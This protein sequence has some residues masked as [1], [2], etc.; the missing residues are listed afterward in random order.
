MVT[1]QH[2]LMMWIV[3]TDSYIHILPLQYFQ[4]SAMFLPPCGLL[5]NHPVLVS[6]NHILS[7][8]PYSTIQSSSKPW[9]YK[10]KFFETT[11]F[12]ERMKQCFILIFKCLQHKKHYNIFFP[13]LLNMYLV[14]YVLKHFPLVKISPSIKNIFYLRY[15]NS[16]RKFFPYWRH[17]PPLKMFPQRRKFSPTV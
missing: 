9:S 12:K 2:F 15:I 4:C 1:S 17:F 10:T 16:Q 5:S 11:V 6:C 14:R 7:S 3:A 13:H 8:Q